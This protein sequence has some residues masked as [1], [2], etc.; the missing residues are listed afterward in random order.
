MA[1]KS[2]PIR[3][4]KTYYGK[5]FVKRIYLTNTKKWI[6][7]CAKNKGMTS[8]FSIDLLNKRLEPIKGL[9]SKIKIEPKALA[10][11]LKLMDNPS[12]V[13]RALKEDKTKIYSFLITASVKKTL[14]KV[15]KF[16]RRTNYYINYFLTLID[17]IFIIRYFS[18]QTIYWLKKKQAETSVEKSINDSLFQ[19]QS[20]DDPAY[21]RY[22]NTINFIKQTVKGPFPAIIVSGPPGTSK[23]YLTRRTLHFS[24]LKPGSDYTIEKGAAMDLASF[25]SLIYNNRTKI[26][27][28][29]DFDS[30]L[31]D[32][33]CV[34]LLKS[35]T[36]SYKKKIVSFPQVSKSSGR[37][38]SKPY[39]IPEKFEYKGK[40]IILTNIA[41]KSLDD[42]LLSRVPS[43]EIAYNAKD[44][45]QN[46][47]DL[48]DSI[49]PEV[50][51][52]I[53]MEVLNYLVTLYENNNNIKLNFRSFQLC[54]DARLAMP[55]VWKPMTKTIV[56]Y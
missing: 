40:V 10:K 21:I 28:L 3:V 42:S 29:D 23:T 8:L 13:K 7:I 47:K 54:L 43:I 24:K 19:G 27:V 25:Y 5:F 36:D 16:G 31:Q 41:I 45:L 9:K 17:S 15:L 18:T 22:T 12:F 38:N 50:S 39:N 30:P 49:Y 51:S 4:E 55:N 32:P 11:M 44:V 46:L 2:T 52:K 34:N 20:E 14:F 33:N 1:I 35:M 37:S 48:K 53:K 6:R 56:R 26:I